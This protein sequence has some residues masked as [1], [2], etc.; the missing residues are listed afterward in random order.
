[1]NN[2]NNESKSDVL[3]SIL[4]KAF[5]PVVIVAAAS[6]IIY[7][8]YGTNLRTIEDLA[9]A[10]FVV[11]ITADIATVAALI[12]VVFQMRE[13]TKARHMEG[14]M[15][16]TGRLN[17]HD[18]RAA[19]RAIYA[20][21]FDNREFGDKEIGYAEEIRA[22][23]N[24]TGIMV[25]EGLFPKKIALRL[26]SETTIK[27]WEALRKHIEKQRDAR[28]TRAFMEDFEWLYN[29]SKRYREKKYPE[30]ALEEFKQT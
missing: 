25:R 17:T 14:A 10:K 22:N 3:M 26:Y 23:F 30:E 6:T 29:E 18:A 13:S 5:I 7:C 1:M 11:G 19:R 27:C 28:G 15:H 20:A 16:F 2:I 8:L 12:F 24:S 9:G 21:H 4:K